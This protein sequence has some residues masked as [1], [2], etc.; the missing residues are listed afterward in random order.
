MTLFSGMLLMILASLLTAIGHICFKK[1]AIVDT[2]FLKKIFHPLFIMGA[3]LFFLCPIMSLFAARVLDFS[4]LY[5]M[6]SLNFVFIL[7]LSHYL[8]QETI[9]FPK[10]SGVCVIIVGLLVMISA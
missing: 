7:L 1:V 4:V 2:T 9:D 3:T 5:G 6:T 10:I 8:L